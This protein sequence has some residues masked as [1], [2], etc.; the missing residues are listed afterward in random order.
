MPV[1][2]RS[3]LDVFMSLSFSLP[4]VMSSVLKSHCPAQTCVS[5]FSTVSTLAQLAM[6]IIS[7]IAVSS[8]PYLKFHVPRSLFSSLIA[9]CL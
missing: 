2:K 5:P 1:S 9:C 3:Y 6:T 8:D 4:T 7:R